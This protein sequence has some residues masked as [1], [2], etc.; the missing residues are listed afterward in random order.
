[1]NNKEF[2]NIAMHQDERNIF[3]KYFGNIEMIPN[4]L[5]EF[6]KKYNPVDVEVTMDGN[7]IH[8]FPVEE[9]ESLQ[10]EYELGS[11]NFVFSTC[12]GDPIFYN[13]EGVFSCYH[14]ATSV[15]SEKLAAN[16]GEFLNLINR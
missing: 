3:E 4:E 11:E 5:K 2:V 8:F 9:L 14:G 7:A 1:M 15:K 13:T 16:F 12:N 10:D 6:F